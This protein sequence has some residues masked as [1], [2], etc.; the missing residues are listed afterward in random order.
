MP[1]TLHIQPIVAILTS[2]VICAAW[3]FA[4]IKLPQVWLFPALAVLETIRTALDAVVFYQIK[5]QQQPGYFHAIS[6]IQTCLGIFQAAL[7]ILLV[8]WLVRS[9]KKDRRA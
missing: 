5:V 7:Y 4:T 3:W 8:R 2:V 9:L 1:N 6:L